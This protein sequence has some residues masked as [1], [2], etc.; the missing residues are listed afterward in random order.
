MDELRKLGVRRIVIWIDI[1]FS[2]RGRP[3]KMNFNRAEYFAQYAGG[4]P[5]SDRAQLEIIRAT[6]LEKDLSAIALENA[7]D[8]FWMDVPRPRPHPFVGGTE[9]EFLDDE[10]LPAL[11]GAL[12]FASGKK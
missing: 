4:I 6:G 7:K 10:W 9:I 8:G 11:S 3:K 1:R 5:I 12:Y 2:W